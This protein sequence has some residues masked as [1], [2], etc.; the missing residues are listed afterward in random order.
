VHKEHGSLHMLDPSGNKEVKKALDKCKQRINHNLQ[1]DF[2][3]T[4]SSAAA[5]ETAVGPSCLYSM[6]KA[7]MKVGNPRK[8]L[9]EIRSI[10]SRLVEQFEEMLDLMHSEDEKRIEGGEGL[11]ACKDGDDTLSGVKIYKGETLLELTERWR[12][13]YENLYDEDS[14][15]FDL[16]RIPDVHDYVRF[17]ILHNPH[18]RV[19]SILYELYEKAKVMADCVVPQE[20]G[21]TIEEKRDIG[22]KVS[23][24]VEVSFIFSGSS[25]SV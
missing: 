24:I 2:D 10:M 3:V 11:R 16:S 12:N 6:H 20:Y 5:R 8:H 22:T 18:L 1:T 14:D 15:T 21:I 25:I 9:M 17:D 23:S 19:A 4:S 7:L 13:L